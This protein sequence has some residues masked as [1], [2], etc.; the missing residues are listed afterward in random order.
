MDYF[1]VDIFDDNAIE[2]LIHGASSMMEIPKIQNSLM[3]DAGSEI[4]IVL[5][6]GFVGTNIEMMYIANELAKNGYRVCLPVLPGH[7]INYQAMNDYIFEDWIAQTKEGIEVLR[8]EKNGRKIILGGHSIGGCIS[9]HISTLDDDIEG[10]F[11]M[12]TPT[13][14]NYLIRKFGLMI[15]K[16]AP[17][18]RIKYRPFI[19]YDKSFKKHPYVKFLNENYGSVNV[20]VLGQVL[21]LMD[22]VYETIDEVTVPV[23]IIVSPKDKTIPKKSS[24]EL[25]KQIKST[26]KSV[27]HVYKAY[28]LITIDEDRDKVA[29]SVLDFISQF[30]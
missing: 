25:Y 9:L 26:D 10:V 15:Y 5:Q 30:N 24:Y 22:F 12:A 7:G 29:E 4:G 17:R 18:L 6:H 8:R 13:R 16:V 19:F 14:Y 1:E 3:G 23:R 11:T 27:E 20:H 21:K 28:H 2:K